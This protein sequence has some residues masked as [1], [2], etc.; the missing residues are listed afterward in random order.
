L[1]DAQYA[2]ND[3]LAS[4]SAQVLPITPLTRDSFPLTGAASYTIGTGGVFNSPRPVKIETAAVVTLAGVRKPVRIVT[5]E[6]WAGQADTTATGLLAEV[7]F[8]DGGY[9]LGTIWLLPKP[10]SGNLEIESYKQL[11]Q[12]A[13]L[14]D[15]ISLA[16]GYTRAL[17]FALAFDMAPE[18]GRPVT[19]ELT[20]L[21]QDAKVSITGLNMAILGKPNTVEPT[22][23]GVPGQ[24]AA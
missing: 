11:S 3:I 5:V 24:A 8:Y 14:G 10:A 18:Y 15:T 6:E 1:T 19:Q 22:P 9:P 23:P 21:A 20:M 12:F 13:N 16:P 4:W 2:A 17:R 7:L